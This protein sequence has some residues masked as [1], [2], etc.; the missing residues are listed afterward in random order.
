VAA[1]IHHQIITRGGRFY[2]DFVVSRPFS[3]GS[4]QTQYV[5]CWT[6]A[7]YTHGS[8][9]AL[10]PTETTLKEIN[11]NSVNSKI[12]FFSIALIAVAFA[13]AQVTAVVSILA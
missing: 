3:V 8:K 10:Q 1:V 6:L 9:T 2:G 5:P 11:M 4:S 13:A 7:K 12:E